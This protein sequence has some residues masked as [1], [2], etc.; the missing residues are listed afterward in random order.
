MNEVRRRLLMNT[1]K[2]IDLGLGLIVFAV[3]SKFVLYPHEPFSM[4]RFMSSRITISDGVL[5]AVFLLAWHFIFTLCDLYVSHRLSTL[6]SE[7]LHEFRATTLSTVL[8]IIAGA[9]V[10]IP[11]LTPR[12]CLL[13][14]LLSSASVSVSRFVLRYIASEVRRR[15]RNLRYLL[16]RNELKS[17]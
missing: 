17:A 13:F 14:W 7:L 11:L 3:T 16:T 1:L 15:G 4:A 2:L 12:F 5:F 9:F 10:S 6:R 8:L